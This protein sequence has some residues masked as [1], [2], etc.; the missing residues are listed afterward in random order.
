MNIPKIPFNLRI[1]RSG[2]TFLASCMSLQPGDRISA[3]D[4][5][6]LLATGRLVDVSASEEIWLLSRRG[7]RCKATLVGNNSGVGGSTCV[8][9][10]ASIA[11]DWFAS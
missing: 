5:R 1:E 6:F 2:A 11:D 7:A 9:I 10:I 4:W 3:V 8:E